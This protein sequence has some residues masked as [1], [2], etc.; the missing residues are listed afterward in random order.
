MKVIHV[1][2]GGEYYKKYPGYILAKGL[3]M[4]APETVPQAC[5]NPGLKRLRLRQFRND[6]VH[7]GS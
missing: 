7:V 3:A 4:A 5:D 6:N 2:G 1:A